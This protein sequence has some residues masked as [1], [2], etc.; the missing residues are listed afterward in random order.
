MPAVARSIATRCVISFTSLVVQNCFPTNW[1]VVCRLLN[2]QPPEDDLD[3]EEPEPSQSELHALMQER[4]GA[5]QEAL[6]HAPVT[7]AGMGHNRPPEGL[8]IEPLNA[9]DR[10]ELSNAL[11][12][13]KAQ[14]VQPIDNGKAAAKALAV[15]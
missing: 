12:L 8:D 7:P 10:T 13:L 2:P 9:V 4:I 1:D 11:Q 15:C 3:F 14:P 6:A 5:L